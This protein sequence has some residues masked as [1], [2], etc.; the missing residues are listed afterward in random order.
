LASAFASFFAVS[1]SSNACPSKLSVPIFACNASGRPLSDLDGHSPNCCHLRSS[2][3]CRHQDVRPSASLCTWRTE[4]RTR[5]IQ[6]GRSILTMFSGLCRHLCWFSLTFAVEDIDRLDR[7]GSVCGGLVLRGRDR[8]GRGGWSLL[9]SFLVWC[10]RERDRRRFVR[11]GV[12]IDPVSGGPARATPDSGVA[13][14]EVS[15]HR[16]TLYRYVMLVY[17]RYRCPC[18]AANRGAECSE[19]GNDRRSSALPNPVSTNPP[20]ACF[21]NGDGSSTRSALL[22]A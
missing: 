15:R 6:A 1:F 7:L 18:S 16:W 12:S 13:A 19:S 9:I 5:S 11:R 21:V 10:H 4:D 3:G 22:F 20:P 8:W 2:I 14:G 17:S